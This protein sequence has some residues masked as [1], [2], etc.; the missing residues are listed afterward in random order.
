[1]KALAAFSGFSVDDLDKA[2]TFYTDV[3]GLKLADE[4]MGLRFELPG[5]GQ[6]FAYD[7]PDH[8]PATFTILNFVVEDIDEAVEALTGK[9]VKFEHYEKMTDEKGVARGLSANRGPDIAWFKEP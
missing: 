5:G 1:M 2:K 8:E 9:G 3:L 7:K 6:V 4:E